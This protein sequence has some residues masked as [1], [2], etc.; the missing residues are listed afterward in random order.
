MVSWGCGVV[1]IGRPTNGQTL[2]SQTVTFQVDNNDR[3][4][5]FDTGSFRAFLNRG[6]PGE[7]DITGEFSRTNTNTWVVTDYMVSE[8]SHTLSAQGEFS[9]SVCGNGRMS[10]D[11]HRFEVGC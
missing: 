6:Q 1:M 4:C 9:G 2:R 8:G 10:S 11:L 5:S 7:I 3:N